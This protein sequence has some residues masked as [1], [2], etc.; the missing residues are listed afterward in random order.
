MGG[1]VWK[2]VSMRGVAMSGIKNPVLAAC[3]LD[4]VI[5][6]KAFSKSSLSQ[7]KN[8]KTSSGSEIISS[9]DG[10]ADLRFNNQNKMP[11]ARKER[12]GAGRRRVDE[13]S[14]QAVGQRLELD[15]RIWSR[16]RDC[17]KRNKQIRRR[18]A[19]KVKGRAEEGWRPSLQ[20]LRFSDSG[21]P[22]E[23]QCV[24]LPAA[25]FR[26]FLSFSFPWW[27][28]SLRF[29]FQHC[30]WNVEDLLNLAGKSKI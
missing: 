10:G 21:A 27:K 4:L 17:R 19:Q 3:F 13:R 14:G 7:H 24:R 8:S 30:M 5:C 15:K 12:S 22:K 23:S 28:Q 16:E 20:L 26:V 18:V 9:Q 25:E 6:Y 1:G 29:V 11:S 2:A